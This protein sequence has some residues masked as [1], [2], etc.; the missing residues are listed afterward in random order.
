VVSY[1]TRDA[2]RLC[3]ATIE[4][5]KPSRSYEIIVVDNA[6]RDGSAELV[7]REFP[8]AHLLANA[9]NLGYSR[10][11]NQA[12]QAARGRYILILN[13]D[14]EA[15]P[16]SIDALAEHLDESPDTGIAG[17]KLLN[18]DGTLQYSCRTFYTFATLLHRRTPLG[19]L[20]PNAKVV[21]DHLMMDWD[22][23]SVRE[24]DWMLGACMMVRAEA[25]RDVGLMDERFFMY[26][27]DV[28]WCYRMKSHGWKVEY[29]PSAQMRHVHRR[30][31]AKGGLF[32]VRLL[33][34]LNSMF[35]FFDKWG[36]VV[37]RARKHRDL[38]QAGVNLVG[39]IVAINLAFLAAYSLRAEL[40][41]VLHR[42]V[43]PF[44]SYEPFIL[45][46]NGV[47]LLVCA[48]LGLYRQG[49]SRE[50]L[51]DAFDLAKALVLSALILMA[52]TFLTRS[53]LQSRFMVAA[54]VPVAFVTMVA[55]RGLLAGTVRALRRRRFDLVRVVVLGEAEEARR[56]AEELGARHELGYEVVT[57]LSDRPEEGSARFREFWDAEGIRD[58]ISRH[59][60]GEVLLVKTSLS[61]PEL[62][63]L[64]L[65]C[66]R[67]GVRI[68]LVS[69]LADFLPG[70][71]AIT[72]LV[73]RPVVDLSSL[74]NRSIGRH[75]HRM[76]DLLLAG[77]LLFVLGPFA[78]ARASR[79]PRETEPHEALHGLRGRVFLRAKKEGS[80]R[81]SETLGHVLRG[82][83]SLVGPRPH[84]PK[85]VRS[86]EELRVLFDLVR[87]GVTGAWRLHEGEGLSKAEELS[88]SLSYLQ[89]R[90]LVEDAKVLL[91]TL[92][93]SVF[94][95][96]SK[97]SPR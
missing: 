19:G 43:F 88:L 84:S 53:E 65:L 56:F 16:G 89:N 29:V 42:P 40:S 55:L 86:A 31:S 66:R 35:R 95:P 13:P 6:S 94:H 73:G 23:D 67:D 32:N 9:E 72:E 79:R 92:L 18:P 2:L 58:V 5:S 20:F 46:M 8:N 11:V 60:V 45:L 74:P 47:V 26:F 75:L 61:G 81:L 34:H 68:R 49:S 24:V 50:L 25:I 80:P 51:D 83:L 59:R 39:D 21:R 76:F 3:L 30:D 97:R 87:P 44:T 90:T 63:R 12:I 17:G 15:F 22:H 93:P 37:Y 10:A 41:G 7:S 14:V 91:K 33:A 96:E 78:W 38:L 57:V 36:T 54:F 77:A 52:S 4:L 48:M 70:Q 85:E 64:V 69:G 28:D 82:E 62:G 71:A 1:N 27:E